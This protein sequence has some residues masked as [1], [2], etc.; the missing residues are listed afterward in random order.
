MDLSP[1]MVNWTV[2]GCS[3]I[4]KSA[5][6]KLFIAMLKY[7]RPSGQKKKRSWNQSQ[8]VHGSVIYVPLPNQKLCE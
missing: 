6:N 1:F 4:L 8:K 7:R 3:N 5:S 2:T